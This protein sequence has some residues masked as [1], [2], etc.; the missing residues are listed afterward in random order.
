[1]PAI[2]LLRSSFISASTLVV[3]VCF[4][5]NV[6]HPPPPPPC[7]PC[8]LTPT[9]LRNHHPATCQLHLVTTRIHHHHS[10]LMCHPQLYAYSKIADSVQSKRLLL[11]AARTAAAFPFHF[12]AFRA[13][14]KCVCSVLEIGRSSC[15][16]ADEYVSLTTSALLFK[17][18]VFYSFLHSHCMQSPSLFAQN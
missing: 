6:S 12:P 1:M 7:S 9:S 3:E 13:R 15:F 14:F 10:P 17:P 18:S 16:G 8:H 4:D 5:S 2:I 11:D